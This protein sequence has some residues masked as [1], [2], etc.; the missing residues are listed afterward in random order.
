MSDDINEFMKG[1]Y[2]DIGESDFNQDVYGW[3]DTGIKP[4]NHALS[5]LYSGGIPMGRVTEIAGAESTGKTAL[6]THVAVETQKKDGIV[7][8][9]DYE[10]A[11]SI[12]RAKKVGLSIDPTKWIYKQP[13]TAEEG[14]GIIESIAE[15]AD[16]VK[17]ERPITVIVDSVACMP[18][19]EE[20]KADFKDMNMK[21]NLSL[22]MVM[23]RSLRKIVPMINKTHI[24]LLFINQLRDN[25][26]AMYGP[27]TKTPGGKALKFQCSVQVRLSKIEKLYKDKSNKEIIG[28]VVKV[29]NKKNK[30]YIPFKEC[31]Y[32]S[33][34]KTGI[35]FIATHVRY[36]AKLGL[37]GDSKGWVDWDGQKMRKDELTDILTSDKEAYNKFL[38]MFVDE[39]IDEETG[40]V[41][42]NIT[43]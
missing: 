30:V 27:K 38:E 36:A 22:A 32:I 43:V 5:G 42:E 7:L 1:V 17:L 11:F 35:D 19:V 28:E 10:H 6:A 12:A 9:L 25:P 31:E 37:L 8:F 3:L 20:M 15:R 39:E 34:F 13:N 14:F 23:S 4:L 24:T 16:K 33:D 29:V 2:K 40:E 26:G 41:I 21:T 18:T